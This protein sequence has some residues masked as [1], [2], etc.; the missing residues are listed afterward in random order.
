MGRWGFTSCVLVV[1]FFI[2]L[3]SQLCLTVFGS[4]C[5]VYL[6]YFLIVGVDSYS[7]VGDAVHAYANLSN[8]NPVEWFKYLNV[9]ESNV[10]IAFVEV[11]MMNKE[12][13]SF[14]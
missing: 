13:G 2:I 8:R 11:L 7:L 3:Y 5:I 9:S 10:C 1:V 6:M 12:T 14:A 4:R